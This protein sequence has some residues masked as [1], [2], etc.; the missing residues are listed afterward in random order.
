MLKTPLHIL[1]CRSRILEVKID[2]L[3]DKIKLHPDMQPFYN[4][5]VEQHKEIE[6]AIE[7]LERNV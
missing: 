6:N 3:K 4:D 7:I 5:Y 1:K 2:I